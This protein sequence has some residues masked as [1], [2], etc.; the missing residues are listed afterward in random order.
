MK[1]CAR[2]MSRYRVK[3]PRSV[4]KRL[5]VCTICGTKQIAT[6]RLGITVAGHTKHFYC[7]KCKDI[8]EHTQID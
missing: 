4:K 2:A 8:T 6:K 3:D 5:F 7:Y 1:F